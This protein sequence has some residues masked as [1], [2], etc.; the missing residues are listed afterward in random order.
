MK[1]SSLSM[2]SSLETLINSL[3]LFLRRILEWMLILSM[4]R[5]S[6]LPI[7]QMERIHSEIQ[8]YLIL[9]R[10][11]NRG[12]DLTLNIMKWETL[13]LSSMEIV[14]RLRKYQLT[15]NSTVRLIGSRSYLVRMN[16]I[17]RYLLSALIILTS[18]S[19]RTLIRLNQLEGRFF[20]IHSTMFK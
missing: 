5:L 15:I 7:T 17:Q 18:S 3:G 14:S 6:N 19:E 20:P 8:P 12:W 1:T 10:N 2:L 11:S 13:D 4:M 16:W 9:S